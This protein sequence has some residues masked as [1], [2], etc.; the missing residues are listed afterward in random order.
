MSQHNAA[1]SRKRLKTIEI[2]SKYGTSGTMERLL[3]LAE[4]PMHF[5]LYRKC[6]PSFQTFHIWM[7]FCLWP[8]VCRVLPSTHTPHGSSRVR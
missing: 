4:I 6:V 7:S 3:G 1:D 8:G 5:W 2:V